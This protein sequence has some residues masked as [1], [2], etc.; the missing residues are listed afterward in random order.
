MKR[1]LKWCFILMLIIS[2]CASGLSVSAQSYKSFSRNNQADGTTENVFARECYTATAIIRASDF[3][4]QDEF[5]EIS[6]IFCADNGLIY[7]LCSGNSE[8]VVLNNDLSLNR[9]FSVLDK[10]GEEIDFEKAQGI[11]VKGKVIYICDTQNARILVTDL[12]GR[13]QS[14]MELPESDIIPDDFVY[15]PTRLMID[16]DGYTY[17]L[18]MGS[19][20]GALVYLQDGTFSGFYGAN[21][22]QAT[23]LDT[24]SYIWDLITGNDT[25][26]SASQKT[27]PYAFVDFCFDNKGYM[28]TCTGAISGGDNVGQINK[29]SPGGSNILYKSNLDGSFS[30]SSGVNFL[31]STIIKRN[32]SVRT[33]NIVAIDVDEQGYIYALDNTYGII[34]VYDSQCNL[35]NAFGGGVGFGERLGTFQNATALTISENRIFVTDSETEAITVF[36]ITDYGTLL[37]KA[38]SLYIAGDYEEAEPYWNQVLALDSNNQLAYKGLAIASY[39]KDDINKAMEY[40]KAGLDYNT[41]DLA[42]Q[43]KLKERIAN[44]FGWLFPLALLLVA[45]IIVGLIYKSKKQIVFITDPKLCNVFSTV[46][47]PFRAF[48]DIKQ[49]NMGSVPI[50]CVLA[51]LFYATTTLETVGSS[52]LFTEIAD[53]NYNTLFTIA[54][55]LGLIVLWS[56]SNWLVCSLFSG[57]GTFKEVFISTN[58][59]LI[60]IIFYNVLRTVLSY[61][62][63]LSGKE[64]LDGI[65]VVILIYTVYLLCVAFTTIHDY[66]LSKLIAT[67]VV[68]V[69]GMLLV[70]FVIFMV[71]ILLQQL[72]DFI[73]SIF[74][75]V[76]YR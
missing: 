23:A 74:V 30:K 57:K 54:Q 4:L 64:L 36:D 59:C 40:A 70:I 16:E 10:N 75:E 25:K 48:G 2:V 9:V 41:Y 15:Q 56:V 35:I 45:A 31:E 68:T 49:K 50:A 13:L 20:Y 44:N 11:Y 32:N 28:I 43:A 38:Q 24:L 72:G 42:F 61:V 52:F 26:K 21:N 27:L 14:V 1:T 33:Q 3:G 55:T 17:V 18:S 47:H 37:K 29:M 66:S 46:M 73:Y 58:Y 65:Y 12:K 71:V 8:I 7:M 51:L 76:I 69:L 19:Y 6:D 34:Y 22:V 60:P 62:M 5:S 67:S 39:K 63:P 53:G